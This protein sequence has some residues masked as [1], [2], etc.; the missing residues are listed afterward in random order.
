MVVVGFSIH[1]LQ[2][3]VREIKE[4]DAGCPAPR[5]SLS[6]SMTSISY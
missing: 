1:S 6:I 3:L 4:S 2:L 5:I